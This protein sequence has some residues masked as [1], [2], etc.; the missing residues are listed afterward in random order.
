MNISVE[1]WLWI[2]MVM[3]PFNPKSNEILNLCGGNAVEAAK[4]IRDGNCSLLSESEKQSAQ[5]IRSGD[6]R[7][8][9]DTCAANDIRIVTLDSEEYPLRLKAIHNPPIVLFVRGSLEGLNDEIPIAVVGTRRPAEYSVRVTKLIVSELAKLGTVIV[10]GCA[11]GLDAAAHRACV[12]SGGKTIAVLGCGILVDYPAENAQLKKDILASGGA[13]ISELLPY[14][15]TFGAYFQHRNRILSGLSSGTLI[16][17]ASAHSGCLLTA[18]HTIEQGRDL[19]CVPPHDIT[20][21]RYAGV[22]P[23]LRDGAIPV[24]SYIDIVNEYIYGFLRTS[25]YDGLLTGVNS[26]MKLRDEG[27]LPKKKRKPSEKPS[28]PA[29]EAAS[30]ESSEQ[31]EMP[32]ESVFASMDPVEACVFRLICESPAD[33]DEVI[34]KSSMSHIDVT[35]ALT[36]LEIIGLISRRMDGKY[37]TSCR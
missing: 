12:E 3:T 13:L 20:D 19:F 35:T 8:V 18:E 5:R 2:L 32:D 31:R 30:P 14:T 17:E 10:S 37:E 34:L 4:L 25:G 15:R 23:L 27:E 1:V 21:A 33:I 24:F 6:V 7:R 9:I 36:D 16:I 29:E 22:M 11:V 26:G 28:E